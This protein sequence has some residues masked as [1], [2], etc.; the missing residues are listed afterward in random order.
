[1]LFSQVTRAQELAALD[2]CA[3]LPLPSRLQCSSRLPGLCSAVMACV[4][5]RRRAVPWACAA[6]CKEMRRQLLRSRRMQHWLLR[7]ALQP[8]W[9]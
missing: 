2:D 4:L 1:V 3:G 8:C 7:S 5:A 9:P 6:A